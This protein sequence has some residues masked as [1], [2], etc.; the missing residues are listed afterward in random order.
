MDEG[1]VEPLADYDD[2]DLNDAGLSDV[3]HIGLTAS[4]FNLGGVW[5]GIRDHFA[6][7]IVA[8]DDRAPSPAKTDGGFRTD[9]R[10]QPAI[11]QAILRK[12]NGNDLYTHQAAAINAAVEGN[13]VV[14]ETATASGKSL[15]YWIPVANSLLQ[16]PDATSLYLS[17]LNAL[18]EDQ[19]DAFDSLGTAPTSHYQAG[20]LAQYARDIKLGGQSL[21]VARYEGTIKDEDLRRLIRKSQP[22]VLI[23][24]PDMLHYGILPHHQKWTRFFSNLRFI[25]IDELHVYR[26]MFGANFAN[27]LR[28]V[29][30]LAQHYGMRPQIVACS[31]SIGN[32]RELFTSVTGRTTPVVIP[33]S[34][35]GAPIR[36]QKR[37]ILDLAKTSDAMPTVVKDLM[38]DTIGTHRART[39]AFMRSISEVDQVY[40]YVSGEL[41]RSIKGI[42]K[43][44]VREYKREIPIEQKA[45]VTA[46]LKSGATLGVISTTALQ[47][48]IDIGDLSVAVI[49]KFPGSKAA[50]FQQAGRVGRSGDSIVFFLADRSPLD[51]WF[52]QRP[53]ELL[54]STAEVVYLNPDHRKT[55]LDHLRCA[56]EELPIDR[57]RDA[58]FW[59]AQLPALVDELAARGDVSADGREVLVMRRPGD[60]A[61]DV[62]IRSLGFEAVVRDEAGAEV[63][64]PDVI[65]AMRRFHKYARFQIQD[66][67]YEVSRLSINWNE[68]TAEAVARK[69]DRLDYSTAS[70]IRTECSIITTVGTKPLGGDELAEGDVRFRISVDSYYKIPSG[71]GNPQYQ[72]LGPA[73][74]PHYELDTHGIWFTFNRPSF[75]DTPVADRGPAVKSAIESLR[76]AA[77]LLCSTDP[78]DILTH[79]HA[80][81]D[82]LRFVAFLADN[83][84]GGNGLTEHVFNRA[85]E[86]V[87]GA[88]RILEECPHCGTKPESRG[89]PQCVTTPWGGAA[90]VFRQGGISLLKILR[91]NLP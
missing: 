78:D 49:A 3:P 1:T 28:R 68:R 57:T 32:P 69:L 27:I 9:D 75:G 66:Q 55:V 53:D 60:S 61:R 63:A 6:G 30:R 81:D 89:C 77:A 42:S 26:G 16:Y 82:L 35:S 15:C 46:D 33:A 65:R 72:P 17:P 70:V 76:I 14:I 84:A 24:N 54:R 45:R 74:P 8:E 34:S 87:D 85:T 64:R 20:T 5:G 43:A 90:D 73:A 41:G 44:T 91:R 47:L 22:R 71:S 29:L 59:G 56:A 51:Q 38:L 18:A 52:A 11:R 25:V 86:L 83:E 62:A 88:I 13:D 67:A 80:S 2:R 40:R 58:A 19:L 10:L 79:V 21:V 4:D 36:R 50:F 7:C 12:L 48:G 31:A 23:T 39:I 37:V